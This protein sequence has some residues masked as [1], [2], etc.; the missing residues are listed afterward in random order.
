VRVRVKLVRPFRDAVGKPEV[1]FEPRSAS[2]VAAVGQLVEQFPGLREHLFERGALSPYV[3][4]Y[5]NAQPVPVDEAAK[6]VLSDGDEL[7]FLLPIT[8]GGGNP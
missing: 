6:H 4:I 1:D 8:G 5:V 2:L 7:L 3:N